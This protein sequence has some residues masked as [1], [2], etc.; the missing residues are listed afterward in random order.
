MFFNDRAC[1]LTGN[2]RL[3]FEREGKTYEIWPDPCVTMADIRTGDLLK[4]FISYSR[5]DSA[6]FTDELVAG[7]ELAGFAP[8]L[9]R[10]DIAPS[11]DWEAR[12]RGLK[13]TQPSSIAPFAGDDLAA[14]KEW[15]AIRKAAAPEVRGRDS[16]W[17]RFCF[18]A[19]NRMQTRRA[20]Q[21][22]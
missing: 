5:R 14:A 8:F 21:I 18:P 15:V 10:H 4:V 2:L 12:L 16:S 17:R 9:D 11:E 3:I 1:T 19:R 22:D 7:L 6:E 13:R 20:A